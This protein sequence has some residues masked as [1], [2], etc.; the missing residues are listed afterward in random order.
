MNTINDARSTLTGALNQ[1]SERINDNAQRIASIGTNTTQQTQAPAAPTRSTDTVQISAEARVAQEVERTA[2]TQPPV[3]GTPQPQAEV[4]VAEE[5]IAAVIV[6]N[7][8]AET[9]F[10]AAA[11]TLTQVNDLEGSLLERIADREV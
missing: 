8:Q 5:N 1:Q 9:A 2:G 11:A 4:Q 6:D 7:I 10:R 3:G